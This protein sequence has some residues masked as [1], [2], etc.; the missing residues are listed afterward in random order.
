M[1]E[2]TDAGTPARMC[3]CTHDEDDH[4]PDDG[5]C[6]CCVCQRFRA[7]NYIDEIVATLDAKIP[8]NDPALLR[9]YAL[10]VLTTG[11][12]T[13]LENVHDAWSAWR[14]VTK[15]DHKSLIPFAGLSLDVQEYDRKYMDVIRQVSAALPASRRPSSSSSTP[16]SAGFR[17]WRSLP[18]QSAGSPAAGCSSPRSTRP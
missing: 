15:P 6:R 4:G 14:T 1:T 8:G 12:A 10:L 7:V 17:G 18:P 16:A 3:D 11:A 2:I 9:L 5:I 13:T